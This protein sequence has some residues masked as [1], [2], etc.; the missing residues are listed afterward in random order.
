MTSHHHH[1]VI[2]IDHHE[3]RVFHFNAQ[4]VETL[5]LHPHN[6]TSHIHHKANT[7][8]SGRASEDHDYLH[9][10]ATS[11]AH[12]GAV[13]VDGP[14]QAD[15]DLPVGRDGGAVVRATGADVR[16]VA[17]D[18]PLVRVGR[19]RQ[20]ECSRRSPE[21]RA[22]LVH[23][24]DFRKLVKSR[25]SAGSNLNSGIRGWP[26]ESP[27]LSASPSVSTGYRPWSVR[28]GGAVLRRLRVC[29]SIE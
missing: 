15:G 3:A 17:V 28:K 19:E 12:A 29:L 20:I 18:G 21:R 23:S 2:W 11:I 13:L 27:S 22:P 26:I 6:P 14:L 4:D 25:T 16:Q 7:I 24:S 8:G 9:A 5:V 1:A 10:I